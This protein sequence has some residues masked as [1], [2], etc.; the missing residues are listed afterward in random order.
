MK[1]SNVNLT[2]FFT[3][4]IGLK[5]WAEVGNLD[6]EVAIYQRLNKHLRAVNFVTYDGCVETNYSERLGGIGFYPVLWS[7]YPLISILRLLYHHCKMLSDSDIIKTNQIMGSEIPIWV[8]KL[9]GKKLIIR[10]GYLHGRFAELQNGK[11]NIGEAKK[12]ERKAFEAAD[13]NVVPTVR[14]RDWVVSNYG[15]SKDKLRIIPNYV[16]VEVFTP[17]ENSKKI[18]YELVFVGRSGLQKNL[19]ALLEALTI[20]KTRNYHIRLLL[21]GGC[22]S[23]QQLK[24]I[25][26]AEQLKVTFL[27]NI[28]NLELPKYLCQ[29]SAFIL[30]SL[31]EGH[32]KIL[33]EAMSCALPCIGTDVEG[34]KELI[35]HKKTGY[36][37]KTDAQNI[38]NAIETVLSDKTLRKSMGENARKYMMEN[39]AIEKILKMELDIIQEVMAK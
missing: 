26:M 37:C 20:L 27:K 19:L 39:F 6:R 23:D 21:I 3:A 15:I 28:S 17:S 16:D 2:L 10:C 24:D 12:L 33:L 5:T 29:A 4:N 31:Y 34:I 18:N 22:A 32:P 13:I 30:P 14:D 25:A 9:F 38:A 35:N 7:S 36:L 8:K 11:K 1:L